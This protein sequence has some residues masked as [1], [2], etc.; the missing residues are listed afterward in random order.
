MAKGYQ[1]RV[2]GVL[3]ISAFS[4]GGVARFGVEV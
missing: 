1:F 4:F 2:D 3:G